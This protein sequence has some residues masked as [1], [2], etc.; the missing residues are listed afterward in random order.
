MPTSAGAAAVVVAIGGYAIGSSSADD[1]ASGTANA[2]PA[3]LAQVKLSDGWYAAVR[4]R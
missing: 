4:G 1:G 2:A 3:H